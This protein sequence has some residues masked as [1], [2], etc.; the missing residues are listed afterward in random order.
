MPR[1]YRCARPTDP[2]HPAKTR[3]EVLCL[4]MRHY[5]FPKLHSATTLLIHGKVALLR[6]D[7]E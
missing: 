6:M 3:R 2:T 4:G 7:G 1:F 5:V